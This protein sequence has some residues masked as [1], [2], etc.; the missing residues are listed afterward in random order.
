MLCNFLTIPTGHLPIWHAIRQGKR[1]KGT[2]GSLPVQQRMTSTMAV[3]RGVGTASRE[4]KRRHS[5]LQMLRAWEIIRHG[6]LPVFSLHT[7]WKE[8]T[9][10]V[11]QPALLQDTSPQQIETGATCDCLT[12]GD[13]DSAWRKFYN[14]LHNLFRHQV[15]LLWLNQGWDWRI[16][17]IVLMG[18]KR[19]TYNISACK[20]DGKKLLCRPSRRW[21]IITK[22]DVEETESEVV[23]C[24]Y[25]VFLTGNNIWRL[26]TL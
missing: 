8:L 9:G 1:R 22:I 14:V 20:L 10:R 18:M 12:S 15:V 17:S 7:T 23:D 2:F 3:A 5:S 24:F 25:F 11:C 16:C 6:V 4:E 19:S 21:E 13:S 26:R